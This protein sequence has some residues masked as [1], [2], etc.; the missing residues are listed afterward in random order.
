MPKF[1]CDYC[2]VYLTHDSMSVRK[3]HN[4]GRNHLRNVVEYYQQIGHEKAQS[5]IDSITNSYAAEGQS[6]SNPMN[7]MGAFGPPPGFPP[8]GPPGGAPPVFPFSHGALPPG[9]MAPPPGIFSP[10]TMDEMPRLMRT[11][12]CPLSLRAFFLPMAPRH[13][14][15]HLFHP[16][17]LASPLSRQDSFHQ[18]R[19]LLCAVPRVSM[20]LTLTSLAKARRDLPLRGCHSL[21]QVRRPLFRRKDLRPTSRV[22]PACR[23][24]PPG[25]DRGGSGNVDS[26]HQQMNRHTRGVVLYDLSTAESSLFVCTR[27]YYIWRVAQAFVFVRTIAPFV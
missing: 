27:H 2:D 11:K 26:V 6:G 17:V 13:A 1:F 24:A 19:T 21:R 8:G 12:A 5:V 3:A 14:A 15:C 4:S 7:Q 10:S 25:V 20:A 9:N 16:Q 18:V 23:A 22:L